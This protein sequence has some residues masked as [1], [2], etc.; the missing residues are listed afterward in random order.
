MTAVDSAV[1]SI[2]GVESAEVILKSG[3]VR[4]YLNT[5]DEMTPEIAEDLANQAYEKLT[6]EFSRRLFEEGVYA[7]SIVVPTVPKGK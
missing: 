7:K 5:I 2:E 3:T 6:Q 4:V 1:E